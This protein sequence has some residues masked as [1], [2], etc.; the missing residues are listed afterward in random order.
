MCHQGIGS[1]LADSDL[2]AL[3]SFLEDFSIRSLLP[4]LETRMRTLYH[5][6]A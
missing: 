5:Q 2:R 1:S 4:H 6:V 3:T